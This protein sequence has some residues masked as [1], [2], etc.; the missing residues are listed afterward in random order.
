MNGTFVQPK[1]LQLYSRVLR[2]APDEDSK[3]KGHSRHILR[4]ILPKNSFTSQNTSRHEH[5]RNPSLNVPASESIYSHP[6]QNMNHVF[7]THLNIQSFTKKVPK[8]LEGIY[9]S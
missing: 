6:F 7:D 5:N 8:F 4:K 2:K 9:K 1:V 3:W